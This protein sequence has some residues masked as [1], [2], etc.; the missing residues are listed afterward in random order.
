[1]SWLDWLGKIL[2]GGYV[3]TTASLTD[4]LG[5]AYVE[6]YKKAPKK[7]MKGVCEWCHARLRDGKAATCPLCGGPNRNPRESIEIQTVFSAPNLESGGPMIPYKMT[8]TEIVYKNR[9]E[10]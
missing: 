4:G 1:M 8:P 2:P 10:I 5:E 7:S 9:E 3:R 6:A